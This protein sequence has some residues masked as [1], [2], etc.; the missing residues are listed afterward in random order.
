MCRS[1]VN[2]EIREQEWSRIVRDAT[3]HAATRESTSS[4]EFRPLIAIEL[5][6]FQG[7]PVPEDHDEHMSRLNQEQTFP[8]KLDGIEEASRQANSHPAIAAD[9]LALTENFCR[10][11]VLTDDVFNAKARLLCKIDDL[12]NEDVGPNHR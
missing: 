7:L 2:R 8:V 10:N 9:I 4:H 6:R 12:I 3:Q 5:R 11:T 1:P